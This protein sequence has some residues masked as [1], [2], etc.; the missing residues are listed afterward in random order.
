[1]T[2][3]QPESP[4]RN[5]ATDRLWR[6]AQ[7]GQARVL[8]GVPGGA[9][10]T[11]EGWWCVRVRCDGPPRLLGP[12][13]EAQRQVDRLVGGRTPMV[14]LA[15][16]RVKS[17]LRRR[18]LGEE[19]EPSWPGDGDL[20]A[21]LNRLADTVDGPSA[22]V[23]EAVEAA[24]AATLAFLARAVARPGWLRPALVLCLRAAP[25]PGTQAFSGP[26]ADLVAAARRAGA[27]IIEP[28]AAPA[29]AAPAAA[30]DPLAALPPATRQVLRAAAVV[31]EGFEVALVGRLLGLEPMEVLLHL[32]TAH[33]LGLPL[34][35]LGEGHFH[36]H[37]PLVQRLRG[38]LLPSL[39]SAWHRRL[40]RHLAGEET[41]PAPAAT[42]PE[43]ARVWVD[44][45]RPAVEAA[46]A[47]APP[48]PPAESA[49]EPQGDPAA[50]GRA[51]RH[52]AEAGDVDL[53]VQ[54]YLAAA[55]ELADQGAV[56]QAL[57]Y[58]HDA[59]ALLE[60][61]PRTPERRRLAALALATSGRL[62]WE[63]GG[64]GSEFTL[65]AAHQALTDALKLVAEG[66]DVALRAEIRRLR[67][68]V[69]YDQGDKE[70]MEQA[71][72]E[73]AE[74]TRELSR[75]GE[76]RAAARLLNDQAAVL[77]ALGDPVR[78][79]HLLEES[80]Q[81]FETL[82]ARAARES[83]REG[84]MLTA[85]EALDRR[86]VAETRHLMARLPLHVG[87]KPGM[88]LPALERAMAHAAEAE[89]IYQSLG[90]ARELAR[91]WQ[92]HGQLARRAGDQGAAREL[93]N[94]AARAQLNHG[95]AIGLAQ[96]TQAMAGLLSDRHEH[97]EALRLLVDSVRL[98]HGKGSPRGLAW[99]R[100]TLKDL[101]QR[102]SEAER[103][104]LAPMIVAV[105]RQ[106]EAA[107]AQLG[108]VELPPEG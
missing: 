8:L 19:G 70:H 6:G 2:T 32:Q 7:P 91:V 100:R 51:A 3:T 15:A 27:V 74:A 58:A 86:E 43:P 50:R 42:T 89:E 61:L 72:D 17:G 71:L 35:D 25:A 95:D 66:D 55:R 69:A 28:P 63:A 73:L 62:R 36:L 40:A 13:L 11:P 14:E 44:P 105:R 20:V 9:P 47:V 16:D 4:D 92:T 103:H 101:A 68:A 29:A 59:L 18:L 39:A 75:A 60:R 78:A 23:F 88:E 82:A 64:G 99:N 49:A 98:N 30:P 1:M 96:T 81:T 83:R 52:S 90:A 97:A 67:A 5:D 56:D 107:E 76:P 104:E 94:R 21:A 22:L 108:R 38:E 77:V 10:P 84:R 33:D 65:A 31:G 24:D 102:M 37:A 87:A 79:A 57:A 12:V 93:L 54:R 26:V 80:L 41:A 45:P 46:P 48:A 53:A 106:L 34:D 85:D